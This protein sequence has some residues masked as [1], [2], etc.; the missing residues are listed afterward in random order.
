MNLLKALA[1]VFPL[2]E[3]NA[4][5]DNELK[6]RVAADLSVESYDIRD[7]YA[8]ITVDQLT[9]AEP[10]KAE[11]AEEAPGLFN[12]LVLLKRYNILRRQAVNLQRYVDQQFN[13]WPLALAG[14]IVDYASALS[15]ID[16]Y[17]LAW[18]QAQPVSQDKKVEIAKA[19]LNAVGPITNGYVN[20]LWH[21]IVSQDPDI[22]VA[23]IYTGSKRGEFR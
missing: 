5:E 3:L 9:G 18:F 6:Q 23:I 20:T 17:N 19:L 13:K 1:K 7:D 11:A 10:A 2:V 4:P 15:A 8:G 16:L 12:Y 22:M 21:N 14:G